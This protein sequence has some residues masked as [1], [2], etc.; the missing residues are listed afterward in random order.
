VPRDFTDQVLGF[1][2]KSDKPQPDMNA[3]T[4]EL[5]T[6]MVRLHL[7]K[8]MPSAVKGHFD[9][10]SAISRLNDA[11]LAFHNTQSS[12]TAGVLISGGY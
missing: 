2:I 11:M 12:V 8:F 10:I 9:C 6:T 3:Y 4:R 5:L 1:H 7:V